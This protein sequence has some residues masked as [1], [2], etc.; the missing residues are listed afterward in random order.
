MTKRAIELIRVSTAGQ[1]ADDRASIPSQKTINER[2]AKAH[3]LTIV[4]TI[5]FAD[6]SGAAVLLAP[7]IRDLVT[8]MADPE[9][10]G[11]VAREFS[12]L[13]RPENFSDYALLQAF[14]DSNTIL[15]L[16]EGPIDFSSKTGRLMG[17]IRAAIAGMERTEILERIW[18][19]KEEKRRNGGF[20][21][22]PVCLPFGVAF[23]AT[24][25]AGW[26]YTDD[27][28]RVQEAFRLVISGVTSY[29]AISRAVGIETYN[30]RNILRNPIYAGWRVIDKKRD[31]S[32]SG[33]YKTKD[34]RQGDRRKVKRSPEEVIRVRVIN[35][36]L[37]SES[38]FE[39]VQR[40]LDLKKQNSWR[41]IEGY[42]HRFTYNGYLNCECGALI[43]TKYR[44]DDY[45]VC[46]V[47]CGASYMRRDRL[48]PM[49]DKLFTRDLTRP[50]FLQKI[51]KAMKQ[52]PTGNQE[53]YAEQL[54]SLEAKR[55]RVLSAFY[56]GVID[57]Q[58]RESKLAEIATSR[59][60]LIGMA[61]R[62]RPIPQVTVE[63][64]AGA[65]APFMEF[66][67]MNRNDKRRLLNT[68]T[69]SVVAANYRVSGLWMASGVVPDMNLVEMAYPATA[70]L[71]GR[72]W[73]KLD[74][75]A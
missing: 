31:L 64:L 45:Y 52:K 53:R 58:E 69:P 37:I 1:A 54:K 32:P 49:L 2:T 26:F 70:R 72:L 33:K 12:R 46:K 3:G 34:G 62:E 35:E 10:H 23:N 22:S 44:R 7:E 39:K 42:E 24:N 75:A 55:Q 30:L 41:H 50:R 47:R 65:F 68:I 71:T 17:T 74:I 56:D 48:E 60:V 36:P 8:T 25:N 29:V 4:K 5:Q 18:N 57:V 9:I 11:V 15:Y 67:L 61:E 16:P 21:Q 20:A 51:V 59:R 19:A 43:Y 66:D 63:S 40:I 38:D 6:V 27:S 14:A 13:M 73:L 28:G